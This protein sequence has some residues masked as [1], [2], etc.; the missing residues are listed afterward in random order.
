MARQVGFYDKETRTMRWYTKEELLDYAAER[1]N[2]PVAPY[3]IQDTMDKTKH[4]G[5]GKMFDSKQAFDAESE[6]LGLIPRSTPL[7]LDSTRNTW[8]IEPPKEA[9]DAL[10][11]DID[12][13]VERSEHMF[14]YGSMKL[15]DEGQQRAKEI[16]ELYQGQTGK[17]PVLKDD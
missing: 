14:K 12:Q 3:V 8:E 6:R 7:D 16:N 1:R 13:A 9:M 5:S 17:S 4:P 2:N 11:A 10:R 15:S